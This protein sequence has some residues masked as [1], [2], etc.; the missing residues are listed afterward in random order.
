MRGV[1][2]DLRRLD[3]E[4][5][6]ASALS[7]GL[8]PAGTEVDGNIAVPPAQQDLEARASWKLIPGL[9]YCNTAQHNPPL[10]RQC[11]RDRGEGVEC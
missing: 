5:S 9:L 7:T 8:D 6:K 1:S 3:E 4:M 2:P 10:A 11:S